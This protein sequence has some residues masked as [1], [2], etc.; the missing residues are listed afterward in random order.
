MFKSHEFLHDVTLWV[1]AWDLS[2]RVTLAVDF[3]PEWCEYDYKIE[4]VTLLDE[5]YM[6]IDND[7]CVRYKPIPFGLSGKEVNY[8]RHYDEIIEKLRDEEENNDLDREIIRAGYLDIRD[9]K[10]DHA[11]ANRPGK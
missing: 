4:S 1:G 7:G 11:M 10:I 9:A 6:F 3:H 5:T 8:E 2:C